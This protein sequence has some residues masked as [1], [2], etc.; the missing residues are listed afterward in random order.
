MTKTKNTHGGKRE[1]AGRKFENG[2][3]EVIQ[4]RYPVKLVREM[5]KEARAQGV[6][7]SAYL[8]ARL[9]R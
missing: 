9:E 4:F 8:R 3:T 5:R 1:G 6:T 7:L 2:P